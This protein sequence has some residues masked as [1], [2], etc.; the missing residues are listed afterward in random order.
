MQL[1]TSVRPCDHRAAPLAP[2]GLLEAVVTHS[3]AL[4]AGTPSS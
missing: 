3:Y 4:P 1:R 2:H